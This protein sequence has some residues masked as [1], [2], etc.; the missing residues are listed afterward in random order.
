ML[1]PTLTPTSSYTPMKPSLCRNASG[2]L[3]SP[4]DLSSSTPSC[5]LRVA[6]TPYEQMP[7][8]SLWSNPDL[9]PTPLTSLTRLRLGLSVRN[10]GPSAPITCSQ[11]TR[12]GLR[13]SLKSFHF[14]SLCLNLLEAQQAFR[15]SVHLPGNRIER[16]AWNRLFARQPNRS[17]ETDRHTS[18][19]VVPSAL[20]GDRRVPVQAEIPSGLTAMARLYNSVQ[21]FWPTV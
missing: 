17:P 5:E 2:H 10:C 19:L 12:E 16:S 1:L 7:G 21:R 18:A 9:L 3:R 8:S 15:Q 6:T 4:Y 14:N 13:Y 11:R 20:R